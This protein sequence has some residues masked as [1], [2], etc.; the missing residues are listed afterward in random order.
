M[1]TARQL[2]FVHK[3]GYFADKPCIF[4]PKAAKMPFLQIIVEQG[5]LFP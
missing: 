2:L 5:I 4:P 1:I 3:A